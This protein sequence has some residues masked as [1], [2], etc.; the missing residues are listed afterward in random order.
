[1]NSTDVRSQYGTES[2]ALSEWTWKHQGYL[3]E[4]AARI[5][6]DYP[7]QE[8]MPDYWNTGQVIGLD[9]K[10]S[11]FT[12]KVSNNLVPQPY[13]TEEAF[14]FLAVEDPL[15]GELVGYGIE[16][17]T[18]FLLAIPL[19]FNIEVSLWTDPESLSN[20]RDV[21]IT[22]RI[23]GMDYEAILDLWDYAS[24]YVSR[25][26]RAT[27]YSNRRQQAEQ[28]EAW[29]DRIVIVLDTLNNV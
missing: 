2:V 1:M 8:K 28:I 21:F 9:Y 20:Q 11:E 25:N 14:R 4:Q 17:L 22:A 29:T 18:D 16:A 27:G 15:L 10:N 3:M 26:V 6:E 7:S 13:F 12:V 19:D 23:A 5:F 24:E